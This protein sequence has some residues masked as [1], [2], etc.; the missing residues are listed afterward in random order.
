MSFLR[1]VII[2]DNGSPGR[3]QAGIQA[4]GDPIKYVC[5]EQAG[6]A[7]ARNE[8]AQRA[9]GSHVLFLD[10]DLI[11]PPAYLFNLKKEYDMAGCDWLVGS[12][13]SA[14][15]L[16][17]SSLVR[18]LKSAE[19]R[20]GN[21]AKKITSVLE[22]S[23]TAANL[24]VETSSFRRLGGFRTDYYRSSCEDLDL[25][26]RALEAGLRIWNAPGLRVEHYDL[27]MLSFSSFALRQYH[28]CIGQ[29]QFFSRFPHLGEGSGLRRKFAS[30]NGNGVLGRIYHRLQRT[31][32]ETPMRQVLFAAASFAEN[33]PV[34]DRMKWVLFR[35]AISSQ[36]MAG[37][38]RGMRLVTK[39]AASRG[40]K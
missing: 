24:L 11:V 22:G 1:E 18:F 7:K 5:T 33:V 35:A 4:L 38:Q 3:T 23:F 32:A 34:S 27:N 37:F 17:N 36:M 39:T 8:G 15:S 28:G 31:I 26:T 21:Q 6:Q 14:S 13:A 40:T 30:S 9:G 12:V 19:A 25:G 29:A 20:G 10:D 2:V 16:P